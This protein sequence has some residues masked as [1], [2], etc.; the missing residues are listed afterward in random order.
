MLKRA[1]LLEQAHYEQIWTV[2][3]QYA[4]CHS[5]GI[6]GMGLKPGT[7]ILE[8]HRNLSTAQNHSWSMVVKNCKSSQ[9]EPLREQ[10]SNMELSQLCCSKISC[11]GSFLVVL[12]KFSF[13]LS[14]FIC[15][16]IQSMSC[17][18]VGFQR[19]PGAKSSRCT[20]R[21]EI[22]GDGMHALL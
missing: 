22:L 17:F 14:G 12:V 8:S 1:N 15:F 16:T 5:V 10:S 7:S 2:C 13:E 4:F 3:I 21:K 11:L 6:S 20:M 9:K 19:L 18:K